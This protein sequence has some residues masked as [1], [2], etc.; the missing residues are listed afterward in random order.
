MSLHIY[1]FEILLN[2]D[3]SIFAGK[4]Q[5]VEL[6]DDILNDPNFGL[7][8]EDLSVSLYGWLDF[9]H[10]LNRRKDFLEQQIQKMEKYIVKRPLDTAS[11]QVSQNQALR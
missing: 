1:T 6:I 8:S 11:H 9:A 3:T 10:D 7:L 2:L 5:A 4:K